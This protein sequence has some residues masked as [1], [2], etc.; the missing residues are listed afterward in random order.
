[1]KC[2]SLQK[3][4][5]IMSFKCISDNKKG[6]KLEQLYDKCNYRLGVF[7]CRRDGRTISEVSEG[8][9]GIF[10]SGAFQ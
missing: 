4:K 5:I 2:D 9:W 8:Y 6:K 1:M 3:V 10:C 7:N